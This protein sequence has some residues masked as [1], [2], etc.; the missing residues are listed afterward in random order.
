[1]DGNQPNTSIADLKSG[2]CGLLTTMQIGK[3]EVSRCTSLGLTPGVQVTVIQNLGH[4]PLIVRVRGTQVAL[5]RK[6]AM[7][8]LVNRSTP[9]GS[10]R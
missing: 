2:E 9:D 1:M 4:G 6:Q 3:G 7:N 5:G 8:L 10:L